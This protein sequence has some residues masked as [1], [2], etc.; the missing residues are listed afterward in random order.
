MPLFGAALLVFLVGLIDDLRRIEPWHKVLVQ[1]LAAA[2]AYWAGVRIVSMGGIRIGGWGLPLTVIWI[3]LCMTAINVINRIDGLVAGVGVI[4]AGATIV[5]ALLQNNLVLA[6]AAIPLAGGILGFLPY[7][8]SPWTIPLGESGSLLIGFLLGC[9]SILWGQR[10]GTFLSMAVS[11]LVLTVPLFDTGFVTVRRFLRRQ[12]FGATD[13]S[14]IYH[15]L[16]NRGLTP[17][18]VMIVL[19]VGCAISAIVSILIV[20]NQSLGLVIVLLFVAAWIW[21]RHLGYAEFSTARR[22]FLEGAFRR[23]L[24]AEITL[25]SYESRLKAACTP[26]EYWVV[27]AEGLNEFGFC[28]AQLSIAG[29][30]FEWRCDIP[31]FGTW[32]VSVPI[33][34][35]DTIRLSR[36]FDTGAHAHG[37]APFVD[38]LRR[39]LTAKRGTFL[40]YNRAGRAEL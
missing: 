16:L 7:S 13:N 25:R 27:V 14:H 40:S 18:K 9:Y 34:E 5:V 33:T 39:S 1:I 3:V 12:P 31:F 2:L 20:K 28:E 29:S 26:E 30:T 17:R 32:E 19:Y 24:N 36:A 35:F 23:K 6:V 8:L 22:M 21:I 11:L 10:S 15:R 38:L 37:F 4:A